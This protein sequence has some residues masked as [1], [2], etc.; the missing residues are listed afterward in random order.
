M[1]ISRYIQ[2]VQNN[3]RIIISK[4]I[5]LKAN[6]ENL[7]PN[8]RGIIVQHN[9]CSHLIFLEKTAERFQK[10]KKKVREIP[11]HSR[12]TWLVLSQHIFFGRIQWVLTKKKKKK[13]RDPMG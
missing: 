3:L 6:L 11:I 8:M 5:T 1:F 12:G 13:K 4:I 7:R 2:A 10:N 9:I